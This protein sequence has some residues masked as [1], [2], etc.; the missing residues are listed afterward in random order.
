MS[1][2][3]NFLFGAILVVI[4]ILAGGFV[5][6]A[7]ILLTPYKNSDTDMHKAYW[8]TFWAAFVTWFLI[9]LFILLVILSI[10]GVVALFGSGVGEAGAAAEEGSA[11][12]GGFSQNYLTSQQGQDTLNEGISWLT[13]GFFIFALILVGITGVLSAIAASAMVQSS[14]YD[15]TVANL[16]TAYDDCIIAA[17]IC[18]GAGG[19]LILGIIIYFIVG[20]ENQ[21]KRNQQIAAI[22]Q[23]KRQNISRRQDEFLQE[24]EAEQENSILNRPY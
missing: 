4:W 3:W 13:L 23:F 8:F 9:A 1:T 19:L 22:E 12:E 20:L 17:S 21:R 2:F 5:T 16:K 18:L 11:A 15:P 10:L 6:K 24:I 14:H 7:N